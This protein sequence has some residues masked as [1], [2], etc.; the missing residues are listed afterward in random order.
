MDAP[1]ELGKAAL[2][3]SSGD[4][5]ARHTPSLLTDVVAVVRHS[6]TDPMFMATLFGFVLML[7]YTMADA[8]KAWEAAHQLTVNICMACL[9]WAFLPAVM[10]FIRVPWQA[11]GPGTRLQAAGWILGLL[12]DYTLLLGTVA[13]AVLGVL[14]FLSSRAPS[15]MVALLVVECVGCWGFL[16]SACA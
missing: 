9:C 1:E 6:T 11:R 3:E 7:L 16:L 5:S 8:H 4:K 2:L 14:L 13:F 15:Y 10:P 12:A